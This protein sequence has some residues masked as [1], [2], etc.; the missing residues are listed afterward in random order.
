MNQFNTFIVLIVL[1]KR[2]TAIQEI[3][4]SSI[5]QYFPMGL[6]DSGSFSQLA[7]LGLFQRLWGGVKPVIGLIP[8]Y[9]LTNPDQTPQWMEVPALGELSHKKSGR[10][11]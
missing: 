10:G 6:P 5:S 9:A 7:V 2:R 4:Y 11:S 8:G 3:R 1:F